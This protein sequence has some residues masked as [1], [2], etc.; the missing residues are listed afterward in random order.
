MKRD[1]TE[2]HGKPSWFVAAITFSFRGLGV[3]ARQRTLWKL[4]QL[5]GFLDFEVSIGN[6]HL[7]TV[8]FLFRSS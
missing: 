3:T 7:D 4:V 2:N 8:I 5:A 6:R 1:E